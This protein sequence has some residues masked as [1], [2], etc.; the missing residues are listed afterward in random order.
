MFY[1]FHGED[2]HSQKEKLAELI[3]KLG[4][5][6]MLELNTSRFEGLVPFGELRHACDSV[7]FLAK[8][9]VVIVQ[10]LL[11]RKPDKG[12]L[13]QLLAYLP[14]LADTA[15][16]FFLE[17][18]TLPANHRLVKLAD[19]ATNGYV[20]AFTRP[21]GNNL[22]RWIQERVAQRGGAISP[23]AV[24]ALASNIGSELA[25]LDNE[26]EKLV[27]Y[28]GAGERIEAEDVLLLSPYAAEANIFDLVDAI[29][30]QKSAQAANL[31]Q[32]KLSDG[33]DPFYLFAMLIRQFR[34]LIQ[35]K[36][37]AE[38]GARP[39]EIA[40]AIGQNA[41]VVGK[42]YQQSHGFSLAQLEQI[43]AHLLD[44][45]VGVKTGRADIVTSLNL[46]VAALTS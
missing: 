6:A 30:G 16:L 19:S 23:R 25:A 27:L 35:V 22:N 41:F 43:Y 38:T 17:S 34:L 9:R 10:D 39:P 8:R 20:R 7:P 40:K 31:L 24:H 3:G 14:Q 46:L 32:Q 11:A 18:R 29:G 13:D 36:E 33:T 1:L 21:E 15:R 42:L 37:V 5:P 44:I 12:Y 2:T 4:D 26:I 45:D 28:K